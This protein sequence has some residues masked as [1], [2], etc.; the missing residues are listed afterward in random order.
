MP[1]SSDRGPSGRDEDPSGMPA[2]PGDRPSLGSPGWRLVPQSPDWDGAYLAAIAEDEDPGDPEEY[3]DPDHA[4]PAGLDEHELAVL[5]AEAR[6]MT[7]DRARA[8]EAA[9]PGGQTGV[10]APLG[11][12]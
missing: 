1:S 6:E 7:A 2:G 5:L 11:A 9:A 8:A 10:L 3:E 4:P 12:P